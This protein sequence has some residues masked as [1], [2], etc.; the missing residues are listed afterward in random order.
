[1]SQPRVVLLD[2]YDSFI[3][4]IK[5]YFAVL[6]AQTTV[7]RIG[8]GTANRVLNLAP[9]LVVLG[10]GPGH[11]VASTY[12]PLLTGGLPEPLP[13]LGV[14]L[15]H[16][17][18]GLAFGCEV[19]RAPE[20]RHGKTSTVVHDGRGC[21]DGILGSFQ[22]VRYHSLV[23]TDP[24]RASPLMVTARSVDDGQIMGLRHRTRPIES[25]QFHPES[26]GSQHGLKLLGSALIRAV[27]TTQQENQHADH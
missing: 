10:P 17:A 4:I 11:P 3:H 19:V 15:G 12:V 13:I 21:F 27:T 22:A 26:I 20:V 25:I 18:V 14:C 1:M 24:L 7:L 5:Q 16:Q 2:A 6:G 23:V 8:E 9:D